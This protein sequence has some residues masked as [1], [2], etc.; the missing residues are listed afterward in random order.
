M[1]WCIEE[2]FV[3]I[4]MAA[5]ALSTIVYPLKIMIL[6]SLPNKNRLAL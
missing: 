6:N 1:K 4:I 3:Q 2:I 5:A